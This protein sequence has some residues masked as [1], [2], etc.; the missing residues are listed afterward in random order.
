MWNDLTMKERA[1]LIKQGV[2]LG[3][4]DIDAIRNN[5]HT[6]SKGSTVYTDSNP[7]YNRL[8]DSKKKEW[9]SLSARR[10]Q[11][12]NL[13]QQYA[14]QLYNDPQLRN[15]MEYIAFNEGRWGNTGVSKQGARGYFQLMPDTI[16]TAS[17]SAGKNYN[18]NNPADDFAMTQ[19]TAQNSMKYIQ[20]L[21]QD[22]EFRRKAQERGYDKYD[23]LMSSWLAGPTGMKNNVMNPK[24]NPKDANGTSVSTYVGNTQPSTNTWDK[25]MIISRGP[26]LP[27]V[28]INPPKEGWTPQ[29]VQSEPSIQNNSSEEEIVPLDKTVQEFQSQV[30]TPTTSNINPEDY[31]NKIIQEQQQYIAQNRAI[32]NQEAMVEASKPIPIQEVQVQQPERSTSLDLLKNYLYKQQEQQIMKQMLATRR[33]DEQWHTL[34]KYFN[35]NPQDRQ[36]DDFYNLGTENLMYSGVPLGTILPYRNINGGQNIGI[37]GLG[38]GGPVHKFGDGNTVTV[39]PPMQAAENQFAVPEYHYYDDWDP[40]QIYPTTRIGGAIYDNI[41]MTKPYEPIPSYPNVGE[42]NPKYYNPTVKGEPVKI[43]HRVQGNDQQAVAQYQDGELGIVNLPDNYWERYLPEV[44]VPG[45]MH[46]LQ[47]VVDEANKGKTI[48]DQQK[49][50]DDQLRYQAEAERAEQD[51]FYNPR[52]V[53]DNSAQ[54]PLVGIPA[55]ISE[56]IYGLM[57][58]GPE[59]QYWRDRANRAAGQQLLPIGIAAANMHPAT[60]A[61]VDSALLGTSLYDIDRNGLNWE[62]GTQ[63]AMGLMGPTTRT[64]SSVRRNTLPYNL[65]EIDAAGGLDKTGVPYEIHPT[66]GYQLK[67]LMEGNPLEKQV[68]KKGTVSINSI[69][70]QAKKGSAVEKSVIERVLQSEDY[71]GQKQVDYNDFKKRVQD[72]LVQET[73]VPATKYKDY[74]VSGLGYKPSEGGFD[75]HNINQNFLEHHPELHAFVNSEGNLIVKNNG[76]W[77]AWD[78]PEMK[79]YDESWY[80]NVMGNPTQIQPY[81]MTFESD[82]IPIGNDKHFNKGTLGHTRYMQV[83]GEDD[84]LYVLESQSDWAQEG[85]NSNLN[86]VSMDDH[87]RDWHQKRLPK[88]KKN[89]EKWE[90]MLESGKNSAGEALQEWAKRDIEGFIKEAK[91]W[92]KQSEN[93]LAMYEQPKEELVYV[94]NSQQ[95]RQIQEAIR[96]AAENGQK[97]VRFPTRQSAAL[98]E[99][100]N[101]NPIKVI[102]KDRYNAEFTPYWGD[103]ADFKSNIISLEEE[104]REHLSNLDGLY[105]Q[106]EQ[107]K[108]LGLGTEE[109]AARLK[110]LDKKIARLESRIEKAK[111]GIQTNQSNLSRLSGIVKKWRQGQTTYIPKVET[112]LNKYEGFPTQY[113]SIFKD[114]DVRTVTDSKG[115][116]WYEVDVP[117]NYLEQEWQ[118]KLGGTLKK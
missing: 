51:A 63:L 102:S 16:T 110:I 44:V 66:P 1:D 58:G 98:I 3:Y 11:F 54:I 71:K 106:W 5:Y 59:G 27:S 73:T 43:L 86:P 45:R 28:I 81:V 95:R 65:G 21:W 29:S 99:G 49:E 47:S 13:M 15:V 82:K 70:A 83:P 90:A 4:K 104:I 116:T 107:I 87:I 32:R 76:I 9:R 57:K 33:R 115:N 6:F 18:I 67:I 93:V 78:I 61:M 75:Q 17:R 60:A 34:G 2:A 74:G 30:T 113:K 84:V 40:E 77:T 69:R 79:N 91:E 55:T 62:N 20:K 22:P 46:Q 50:L 36:Q 12:L 105:K 100:Y 109:E 96:Q 72:E 97:K 56:Y 85:K 108:Q 41:D 94:E 35:F 118:Y 112:I 92:V 37:P 25:P 38:Y 8:P 89:L 31:L 24:Y 52:A 39:R 53:L 64:V 111:K 114:A 48:F 26:E 88:A 103:Y 42:V 7:Y 19:I 101:Q 23:L 68:S 14:P 117:E 80:N 10:Q